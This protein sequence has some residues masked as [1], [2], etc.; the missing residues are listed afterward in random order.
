MLIVSGVFLHGEYGGDEEGFV[1]QL[2]NLQGQAYKRLI[3]F[4]KRFYRDQADK[5]LIHFIKRPDDDT[6]VLKYIVNLKCS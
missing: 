4:I 1:P 6:L 2:R 5:R 3:H